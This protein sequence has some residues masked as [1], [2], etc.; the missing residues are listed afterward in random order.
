MSWLCYDICNQTPLALYDV[1]VCVF[2]ALRRRRL[3]GW[4]LWLKV[5]LSGRYKEVLGFGFGNW[6]QG[7][8]FGFRISPQKD[9]IQH[10]LL[11]TENNRWVSE[12]YITPCTRP[13]PAPL[14]HICRLSLRLSLFHAL[15]MPNTHVISDEHNGISMVLIICDLHMHSWAYH[16][17]ELHVDT[18]YSTCMHVTYKQRQ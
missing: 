2:I 10:T 13:F 12:S 3:G 4:G 15:G 16:V 17:R 11:T 5:L 1:N 8:G 9:S 6:G 7:K 18:S 14:P